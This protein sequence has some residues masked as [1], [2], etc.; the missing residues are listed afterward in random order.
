MRRQFVIISRVVVSLNPFLRWSGILVSNTRIVLN[1]HPMADIEC[2]K[3]V[4]RAV[5]GSA[6]F[7]FYSSAVCRDSADN[8]PVYRAL[9]KSVVHDSNIKSA[10]RHWAENLLQYI[11]V[12]DH[13]EV[14]RAT[15]EI[16]I[17]RDKYPKGRWHYLCLPKKPIDNWTCLTKADIPLL[18]RMVEV[19]ESFARDQVERELGLKANGVK[20]KSGFH[21]IP[22]MKQLH[23]HV[24]SCDFS[25]ATMR[26]KAHWNAFVTDFFVP[27]QVII[28]ELE[29][30]ER[31]HWDQKRRGLYLSLLM[32]PMKCP[33][34]DSIFRTIPS[35]KSH[36]LE[37]YKRDEA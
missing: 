1:M 26:T 35:L 3:A 15:D 12:A 28:D 14:L 5:I 33:L 21:A 17:V 10:T 9:A 2:H 31:I 36:Y 34:C 7:H 22:S 20:F 19:S 13:P 37:E 29:L 23:L 8:A 27:V 11:E 4:Y 25:A 30:A 6:T 32:E 18:R 24:I 16:V